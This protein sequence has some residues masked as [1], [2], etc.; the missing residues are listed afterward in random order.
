MKLNKNRSKN[1][2]S[3]LRSLEV[4]RERE[5]V[6]MLNNT[7]ATFISI[8]NKFNLTSSQLNNIRRHYGTR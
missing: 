8:Q 4:W 6:D 7:E 5:V 3:R 1:E 2:N